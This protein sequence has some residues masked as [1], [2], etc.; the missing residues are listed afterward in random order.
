MKPDK[1]EIVIGL[2]GPVGTDLRGLATA[3]GDKLRSFHYECEKIRVSSLIQS[4]CS[5]ELQGIISNSK[6]GQR[7]QLLM[8][9][10][11]HLRKQVDS[12]DALIPLIVTAIRMKRHRFNQGLEI[13]QG[14][15]DTFDYD[16]FK[17]N[18]PA[19]NTCYIIDSLKH[20]SEIAALRRIYGENF[21]L[22]SGFSSISERQN[23]LCDAIAQSHMSTQ[24]ENFKEEAAN[25]ISIDAK[26]PGEKLGQS[27]RDTFPLA[28]FFIRVS[29]DFESELERFFK[30]YFG[31]P[32]ITPRKDEF[33]M[34][35]AKAKAYRSADLS[36]QVGAVIT[37]RDG[38]LISYGCN[39]VPS[40]NG[41]SYWPDAAQKFDN[42]DH[43]K[44]RDYNSVKKY[45][46]INELIQ[47]FSDN[48]VFDFSGKDVENFSNDLLFGI[49]REQFKDLRVS[50]LI[51]FG[52]VVHAEMS[53]I[54][55][56]ANR[57]LSIGG[58]SIYCTTFPCHMCARH[59]ISAG[60]RRVVYIEPYPKSMTAEL[61]P[62]SVSIDGDSFTM[63]D[64][65]PEL[66]CLKV[67]FDPF[68]GVAPSLYPKLYAA[69]SGARK[70][71]RG[72]TVKWDKDTALPKLIRVSTAHPALELPFTTKVA[73]L[74][75][76]SLNDLSD[77]VSR[78]EANHGGD[79][80]R[81]PA[82]ESER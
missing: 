67:Q 73:N 32:Y 56:A 51:E 19:Y 35:E 65:D 37:D 48:E 71:P 66:D 45:E 49:Y 1:P 81:N 12:G 10:G 63:K 34:F 46:I 24:N 41:G 82:S 6:H 75:E 42:R 55:L 39:E 33:Y 5:E 80:Q 61:Y 25:L 53:A 18:T 22:I 21:I 30:L 9:A 3:I 74:S 78:E 43:A 70:D 15:D 14:A 68:E 20:E 4:F 52:R 31:N 57:G 26:R 27:L 44:G 50:N 16:S 2:A 72:Y 58:G 77:I 7:I 36:R 28:D 8:A 17:S 40:A 54:T 69:G 11:D 60:L 76:V 47:F 23:R 79:A 38:N 59:I 13:P 29:G 64:G 62:E